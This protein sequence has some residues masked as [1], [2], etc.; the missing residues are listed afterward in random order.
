MLGLSKAEI[1]GSIKF[2]YHGSMALTQNK[3]LETIIDR[4]AESVADAIVE[5][6]NK[7][8]KALKTAG[9]KLTKS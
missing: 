2:S 4:M 1:M 5:N 7:I 8:E 6:N 9:V 3:E